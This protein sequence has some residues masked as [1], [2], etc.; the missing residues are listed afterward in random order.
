LLDDDKK[1]HGRCTVEQQS[2]DN[3]SNSVS[4]SDSQEDDFYCFDWQ[5]AESI[6]ARAEVH[7]YL[8]DR[9]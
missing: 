5:P 4:G 2:P 1:A 6:D 8:T 9:H 3:Q 7:V